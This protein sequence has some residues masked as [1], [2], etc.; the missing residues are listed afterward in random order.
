MERTVLACDVGG[1]NTSLALMRV[2]GR[3][4]TI[5]HRARYASRTLNGIEEAL[6]AF[7]GQVRSAGEPGLTAGGLPA[8]CISAAGPIENGVCRLTNLPWHVVAAEVERAFGC[9]TLLINDF[10]AISYG[11][12][13]LDLN[14][15]SQTVVLHPGSLGSRTEPGSAD[16]YA[17]VGAGTGLGVGYLVSSGE[18]R[19]ALPSEGGH[20][21]FAPPDELAA[22]MHAFVAQR[23]GAAVGAEQFVSGQG[24]ANCVRFMAATGRI[25]AVD[26]ADAGT[27]EHE[28]PRLVS[29]AAAAGNTHAAEVLRLFVRMYASVAASAALHFFPNRGLFLAGGIA[30]KNVRWFVEDNAFLKAFRRSYHPHMAEVLGRFAIYIVADY[31]ISLYGAAYAASRINE[32]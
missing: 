19:F 23:Y 13:L 17:V 5:V 1:T 10:T 6:S 2:S 3:S 24:I 22:E 4:F 11:V 14:D 7:D 12:A 30:A 20:A 26:F 15:R 25:P 8:L 9:R 18:R 16:V 21:P 32:E 27:A 31:D 28:L 29:E